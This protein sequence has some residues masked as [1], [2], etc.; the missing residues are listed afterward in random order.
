MK[1]KAPYYLV[2]DEGEIKEINITFEK[3]CKMLHVEKQH[4][5]YYLFDAEA[6]AKKRKKEIR[7]EKFAAIRTLSISILAFVISIINL[8]LTFR[9]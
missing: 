1:K 9:G 8:I 6:Y 4:I 5:Y 2:T 7:E 3:Y